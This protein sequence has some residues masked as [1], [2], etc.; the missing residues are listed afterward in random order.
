MIK[1][2]F[3][4]FSVASMPYTAAQSSDRGLSRQDGD[5]REGMGTR[6]QAPKAQDQTYV[7]GIAL[8]ALA[9]VTGLVLIYKDKE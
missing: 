2:I 5:K 9:W 6:A 8:N 1:A 3:L 4:L 7:Y